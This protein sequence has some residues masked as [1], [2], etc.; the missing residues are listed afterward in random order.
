MKEMDPKELVTKNRSIF[1][2]WKWHALLQ[3]MVFH[4]EF[5]ITLLFWILLFDYSKHSLMQSIITHVLP[6]ISVL[7]EFCLT[8]WPFT[9]RHMIFTTGVTSL[10]L[11]GVNLPYS[12]LVKPIYRVFDWKDNLYRALFYL[13]GLFFEF[14]LV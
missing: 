3:E 7:F 1:K 10:Y 2:A 13:F 5:Q 11:L 14:I 4:F 9:F 8:K 6:G 12:I